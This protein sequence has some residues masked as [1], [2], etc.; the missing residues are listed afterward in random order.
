MLAIISALCVTGITLQY[1]VTELYDKKSTAANRMRLLDG[2]IISYI[3][4]MAVVNTNGLTCLAGVS[5]PSTSTKA[6][7]TNTTESI[8]RHVV[9][10]VTTHCTL[11]SKCALVTR[12]NKHQTPSVNTTYCKVGQ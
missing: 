9:L 2:K 12:C 11:H 1:L 10:T 7:G 3:T 4:I 6:A 5:K 8:T